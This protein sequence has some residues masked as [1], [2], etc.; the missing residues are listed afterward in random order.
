MHWRVGAVVF[1]SRVQGSG[2]RTQGEGFRV[3]G[4]GFRVQGSGCRVQVSGFRVQGSEW[5]VEPG[6]RRRAA[7]AQRGRSIVKPGTWK[8]EFK[9]PWREDGPPNHHDDKVD[10]DQ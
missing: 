9:L 1:I 4:A 7:A 3:Q 5:R 6:R 2:S 8:T 10:S